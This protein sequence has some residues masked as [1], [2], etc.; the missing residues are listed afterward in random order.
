VLDSVPKALSKPFSRYEFQP[1]SLS[2]RSLSTLLTLRGS[3]RSNAAPG[4]WSIF[5]ENSF[6]KN[7]LDF[8]ITP[9]SKDA[10]DKTTP[11]KPGA[12][13]N[14]A[15]KENSGAP[16]AKRRR[17]TTGSTGSQTPDSPLSKRRKQV[18]E[19]RFGNSG[20]ED[21]GKAIERVEV[22]IDDPFPTN[23]VPAAAPDAQNRKAGDSASKRRGRPSLLDRPEEEAANAPGVESEDWQPDVRLTFYGTHVFAGIRQ[24]AEQ[25]VVD[26]EKMP[27]WMTG[28]AGVSVGVVKDGK[29]RKRIDVV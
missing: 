7:A 29:I 13:P 21:D 10:D 15:D 3:G 27:G 14:K 17:R 23:V 18:A 1:T 2:T 16:D 26:G 28:E 9:P 6:N 8:S 11:A 22:R 24:L 5:V 20:L 25:G 12:V 19:G 4:G